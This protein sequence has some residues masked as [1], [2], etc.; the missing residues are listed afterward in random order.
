MCPRSPAGSG[1]GSGSPDPPANS[2]RFADLESQLQQAN[3]ALEQSESR[4]KGLE[5]IQGKTDKENDE[6]KQQLSNLRNYNKSAHSAAKAL[7]QSYIDTWKGVR[8]DL[9]DEFGN[10]VSPIYL[11]GANK[12][13][14]DRNGELKVNV[15][16]PISAQEGAYYKIAVKPNLPEAVVKAGEQ[17]KDKA[18]QYKKKL[19]FI[20]N[21]CVT[22]DFFAAHAAARLG[23]GI[24]LVF[25]D[26]PTGVRTPAG[27]NLQELDD[28]FVEVD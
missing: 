22:N 19:M 25:I 28:G 3:L 13:H 20:E 7:V 6:L 5:G 27:R 11:K 21:R 18:I 16:I 24:S 26:P 1:N 12:D 4:I 9:F 14:S 23:K 2:P 15:T 8:H 17:S 10:H